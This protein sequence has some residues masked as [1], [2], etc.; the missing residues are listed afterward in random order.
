MNSR[1]S[2]GCMRSLSSL[3][4]SRAVALGGFLQWIVTTT[5]VS[6]I[7]I[8]LNTTSPLILIPKN[9][10]EERYAMEL[11]CGYDSK[12]FSHC[13]RLLTQGKEILQHGELRAHRHHIDRELLID[14]K[15]GS[16]SY[17]EIT[18]I[19]D[20]LQKEIRA[21]HKI[22]SL[23]ESIDTSATN[24]LYNEIIDRVYCLS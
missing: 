21:S 3:L 9:R 18:E 10:N 1:I 16:Y 14:I 11:K 2:N 24:N 8:L 7:P 5:Y 15:N 17:D 22:S 20:T 4:S 13:I 23:P 12:N 19:A 6:S